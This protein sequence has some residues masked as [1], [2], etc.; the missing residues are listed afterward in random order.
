MGRTKNICKTPSQ[1]K[2]LDMVVNAC[3]LS[4]GRELKIVRSQSRLAEQ[5]IHKTL[6][7]K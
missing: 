4:Y 5:K 2:K 1:Q 3:H 6:S 7:P